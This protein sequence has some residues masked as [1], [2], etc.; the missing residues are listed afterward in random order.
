MI[1]G[2][3]LCLFFLFIYLFWGNSHEYILSCF[4]LFFFPLLWDAAWG[5]S[6]PAHT[7]GG[8]LKVPG[9]SNFSA[10]MSVLRLSEVSILANAGL[11]AAFFKVCLRESV[12]V[13]G[14]GGWWLW[15]VCVWPLYVRLL[16][17]CHQA[18]SEVMLTPQVPARFYHVV[19]ES[20]RLC[21]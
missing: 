21:D 16:L 18:V 15:C 1:C 12:R 2:V 9:F 7:G 4:S 10:M 17:D 8:S 20:L 14:G 13:K 3:R 19:S 11:I 5:P 6:Q